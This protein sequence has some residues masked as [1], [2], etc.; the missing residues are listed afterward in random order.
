MKN[1]L[2]IISLIL[3]CFLSCAQNKP[4]NMNNFDFNKAWQEV[5]D[6]ENK[7]LP[8]S[9]LKVVNEIYAQAKK[10]KNAAQLVKGIIHQL[11]FTDYKEEN[12]FVKNLTRLQEES[13]QASYP[14]KPL[15]HSMLGEMY[16]QYY[17]NNRH[18]FNDRTALLNVQ[19]NDIETWSLE[20]IV[21]ETL[22]QYKVSLQDSDKSKNTPIDL[23]LDV[24]HGGNDLGRAYRPTLYDFLAHR[25]ISFF[26]SEESSITQPAFT[27]TLNNEEY[28]AETKTFSQLAITTRDSLSMKFY[29]LTL[30]QDLIKFHRDDKDPSA[31]VEVDLQRLQFVKSNTTLPSKNELYIK[32]LDQLAN[33]VK[34]HSI[35]TRISFHIA[36]AYV[37]FAGD[38]KPLLSEDHKW[39]A[40][41]AYDLCEAAKK[42][43]PD[44]DGAILCEH[45]QQDIQAKTITAVIEENNLPNQPFRSL[46][47]YKNF[48]SLYYRIIKVNRE[49]VREQ[50][51]KWERNYNEDQE[52]KFIEYFIAK[53]PLKTGKF[54]LPDDGDYQQHSIE[55]KIDAL[56]EGEYM[57]L[58]SHREDFRTSANGL[59]YSFT[60]ISNISW[61]HR[62]VK[63]GST[64]FYM[65]HRES[66]E[67]L[68][69]V[70]AEAFANE[71]NYK[72][73]A[74]E[75]VKVGTFTS[76]ANGFFRID[77]IKTDSRRN[78]FV[79]FSY[80][81]DTNSTAPID[82]RQ[83]YGGSIYQFQQHERVATLHT[84]F[85]LDRAIY[86]PGQTIYF[87]G[88][89]VDTDGK[90]S[91][92]K[93]K[94]STT[95]ALY[96]A[97]HQSRGELKVTT[98]EYGT[99][100][101]TFIAPSTG[102]TGEMQIKNND[103]SGNISFSV[104]EY[105][106]PKFEVIVEPIKGSFKLNETVK[107]EGY[108]RAYSGANIDGAHV[109][110][111]VVRVARFPF[112]WWC[113]WGYYP[114]APDMEITNGIT[115]TNETG[116]FN[117]DFKAIPDL[118]VER[119][120][121]PTF[122]YTLHIDVT[123][124]NGETHSTSS[125]IAVAY[126]ALQ[127]NVEVNDINKREL[128]EK[129]KEFV[130]QT[131]NLAGEFEAAKGQIKIYLLKPPA[132]IFRSRLWE[133]ADRHLYTRKEY[134]DAF[135]YDQFE[136][137]TNVFKWERS[138]EVFS[139]A[140]D[141]DNKKNFTIETLEKWNQGEYVLEITA[142]D[143]YGQPVKEV[144][145][146]SVFD[147]TTKTIATPQVNYFQGVKLKSEPGEKASFIAGTSDKNAKVLYE[148]EQNEEIISKQ[149]IA[150]S[151]EQRLFEILIK[152]EY[153]GNVG[154]HYTFVKNNRLYAT[155]VTVEV[156]YTN[157]ELDITFESF[158][159]KL[160][161]GQ[162]EQWKILIKGK[163]A[164]KISAE[165]VATL[166]DASLDIF[167][168]NSWYASFYNSVYAQ[169]KWQSINGFISDELTPYTQGWNPT[170]DRSIRTP[171]Y[172]A[173]NWFGYSFYNNYHGN[174]GMVKSV[175]PMRSAMT[176]EGMADAKEEA[177]AEMVTQALSDQSPPG[178]VNEK[179]EKDQDK[180]QPEK[181][182]D[183]SAVKVR[184]NFNETAFFYPDLQTNS[185]GEIII[186]FTIPEA[187]TRWKMLGFAHTQDLK[188]G[189]VTNQLVTQ[190]DLMV[191]PNQPRF[192]RENDKMIFAVKLSS[193]VDREMIGQAQL[194]FFDAFSMKPID[195]LMKNKNKH[196]SFSLKSRQST[197]L[198][199]SIEIPEGIQ[200]ILYRV[201]AKSGNF[202]DGEEMVLPVVTN[203]MLVTETLPLPIRGKQRKEFRFE[204][205]LT[206]NSTTLRHQRFTL[207]FTSNPAWYAIQALPYLME[208]PYDCTEQAFCRYYANS[209]A[210]SIA[211]SNPRIKQV[212]D[213]WKNIQPTALLSNLE[214]NQELKSAL[215]EETPW[216]LQ[217]QDE[218]QRK[219]MVG[220]LF[221]LNRMAN[222]QEKALDKIV[223]AQV[224][225]GGFPWFPG[226]PEDRYMTQHIISG[227]GHLDVMG[228]KSVRQE[229]RTWSMV[230]KALGY[231]DQ[232]IK[233]D[234]DRLKAMANRKQIKLEEKQLTYIHIHYLY[235][236]S[237]FKDIEIP[238]ATK[239]AFQ[240][241][242]GQ[243]K[244]YWLSNNIYLEGMICLA[245]HRYNDKT[246]T[247]AMIK[248]FNERSLHS[249]E[250][251]MYW[252]NER[253]YYWYYAAIET[254]A[255][256]IEVYDEV[257]V[258][259]KSV[260]DLKVWLLK[261][262][263]TQDWKTTKATTEACYAL[264]RRGTNLLVSNTPVEIK[265]GKDV[266]DPSKREDAKVEAGTGYF[267]TAWQANEINASMGNIQVTKSDE[268]VAWGAVYWQY[269]EQLDKITS[270][271][272][273]LKIKKDIFKQQ[274]TDRG[275]V[276]TPV[277]SQSPLQIGDLVKIRI[278]I[279]V[280]RAM[281]YVHLK[282]MRAAGFE[283]VSTLSGHRYQDGLHYYESTRDLST[284][285]FIGYLP[286]GTYVF[287][288]ALRVSQ[289]GDFSNGITT[290]QCM[291]AP[292]FAS[293]SQGI[294]IKMGN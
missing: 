268:G 157:K 142:N 149:W 6:F 147:P 224:A 137:E 131:T 170:H 148:I 282:D 242:L 276:I 228:V 220:V 278:E 73:G 43:F 126:K 208:Y 114:T 279:R 125:T 221:D 166:Y 179:V 219:R 237:F 180:Q 259:N 41:K 182:E 120:A 138:N 146:F 13:Q 270:A 214:K 61:I 172:D 230:T 116:K 85:F 127:V 283:P 216:V 145:Y 70:K 106:R 129:R 98:N 94:Y 79:F 97:N 65:L 156:P 42:R 101:G 245:L 159:D 199:W 152:E 162:K 63:D 19:Q 75:V 60:A 117:I 254:Q 209:I 89:V 266:I 46:V 185:N 56:P 134:Y 264:L 81:N 110:Y 99:F 48:T 30:L 59:A 213:T 118:T 161:P 239:E 5:A 104:E 141:T 274:N 53:S 187:L 144:T 184:S 34:T 246:L 58:Y 227:M 80:R 51:K 284:N 17:Q 69:G 286:K 269:F 200:A 67:P 167:R 84:Y 1:Q 74:Y 47:R 26:S 258:D 207:E 201:V 193:L 190:K 100:N 95:L 77:F 281:E 261:Q 4:A 287:E 10:E 23:Y 2:L 49:E 163:A 173:L 14:E 39:D 181:K 57:V 33:S 124:I 168:I 165:M 20:K 203:R 210:S 150:L 32:A 211:N 218:T 40:K 92:I 160:Q 62:P 257:A 107:T 15:L 55:V 186:N 222:E 223:K 21:Q 7:G 102:L 54:T 96:D 11:K 122:D 31:F 288:Y 192:F 112:W 16:W 215:L 232:Q 174:R 44:S 234:Y 233:D 267:K 171:Y 252:K 191:V 38:Y 139:L 155:S 86:R 50:R 294:R 123:D 195:E 121:D 235:T 255:L 3:S 238:S 130:I 189:L 183:F 135:P 212:F 115:T 285:F 176:D 109:S 248:S 71:Y 12:A 226:F 236:R 169:K 289:K 108:A 243:A 250:M 25:A 8:E 36:Q 22:D 206:N 280:D 83:G 113:R 277:T 90:T 64:E 229:N 196:Q 76:D 158:R 249:E 72:K 275:P 178:E 82:N 105:K 45:L 164:E 37:E 204:K 143:K 265:I 128:K 293:H 272:T 154:I 197:S 290:A 256:M 202:S 231:L 153:R 52:Q 263:Q 205:M 241:F 194:E 24:I 225:S 9:A 103:N 260:E 93:S 240:Y 87:K 262:K 271:E 29:A 88:L 68:A 111:R 251:G 244:K 119:S 292:E 91:K 35:S 247:A 151:N 273:P 78:F 188:S 18:R 140:F 133:Q 291:Y 28:L 177:P 132:K 253:G 175:M 136:D 27:F 217:A 66:G 198:E